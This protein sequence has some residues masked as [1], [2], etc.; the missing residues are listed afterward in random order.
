MLRV[1]EGSYVALEVPETQQKEQ[2]LVRV[3]GLGFRF[4]SN[5]V[6]MSR[7]GFRAALN[8]ARNRYASF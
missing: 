6:L 5:I 7:T 2:K 3:S 1:V 8:S 4:C